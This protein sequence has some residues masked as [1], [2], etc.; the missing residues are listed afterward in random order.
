MSNPYT[1]PLFCNIGDLQCQ[2][3]SRGGFGG[4]GLFAPVSNREEMNGSSLGIIRPELA[5]AF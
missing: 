4:K 1:V 3:T 2:T 5:Q